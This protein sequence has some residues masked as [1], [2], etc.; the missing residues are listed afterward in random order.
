MQRLIP[1]LLM[2]VGCATS[3]TH[4]TTPQALEPGEWEVSGAWTG[5][6]N[7]VAF[8]KSLESGVDLWASVNTGASPELS[9]QELRRLLDT[10]L[11]WAFFR[12]GTGFE[13]AGRVGLTDKLAEGLDLGLRTDFSTFKTDLK[14]QAWE[15]ADGHF[16]GAVH[17]AYGYQ[18]GLMTS[19]VEWLSL[20]NFSRHDLDL[21]GTWGWTPNE[22]FSLWWGPRVMRS[23]ISADPK[24][25]GAI[26]DNLPAALDDYNPS[27]VLGDEAI[28][29]LGTTNG[30]RLGRGHVY[31]LAELSMFWMSFHPTV[32]GRI[33]GMNGLVLAPDVALSLTW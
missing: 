11:A 2:S 17:L 27:A 12:P 14:L 6:L 5:H 8:M 9:E 22:S 28:T 21:A 10:G 30:M 15:S 3:M 18:P 1:L 7:S 32:L 25:H 19:W 4:M 33:R 16:A 13:L 20:T 26:E 29:Y 31:V 24:L 23:W